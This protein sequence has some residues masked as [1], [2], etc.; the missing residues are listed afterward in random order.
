VTLSW[1]VFIQ[2]GKLF[3]IGSSVML[4]VFTKVKFESKLF[5]MVKSHIS[6]L[7]VCHY[8]KIIVNFQYFFSEGGK[9]VVCVGSF[10]I[11]LTQ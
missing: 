3:D 2:L 11:G 8:F 5:Y 6:Y 1:S 4:S 9:R 10:V 7:Y